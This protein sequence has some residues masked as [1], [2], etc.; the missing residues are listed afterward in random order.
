MF[1][2]LYQLILVSTLTL[3][4]GCASLPEN[5]QQIPSYAL[6]NT[7]E[8]TIAKGVAL[9]KKRDSAPEEA[10]GM[11]LIQDGLDA[12]VARAGLASTAEKTLDVQY[13]LFH[14]DLSGRLLTVALFEAAERGVRVR[15]LL[16]DMDM[17]G[18]DKDLATLNSHKNIQIRLFNPFI[19]GKSRTGQL[20]S[21]FGT[22][23]RRMHNKSF[24]A[25]N[26]IAILGGRNI[27][28]AYFS[29]DPDVEF[30]DLDVGL[31][32]P[33]VKEVS[34]SFDLYWNSPLAY[35][36]ET[37][38]NIPAKGLDL[39]ETRHRINAYKEQ[40][41]DNDYIRR[42]ENS[43]LVQR[44]KNGTTR[45]HWGD[46]KVLADHPDKIS[47]KRDQT[48][49]H[50]TPLLGPYING[51]ENELIVVSP[52]FVPGKEGVAFFKDLTSRGVT[53]KIMT[54]SLASNDVPIVHSGYMSYRKDLLEAG[55]LLYEADKR[56]SL[57]RAKGE[58]VEKNKEKA[59][60][61]GS[62][63]SKTS[64]HAKYFIMDRQQA[65][66]GSL[67]LDPRSVVENTE[68]GTL[69]DQ[70]ELAKQLA[71]DFDR[72]INKI[73]FDVYLDDGKLRWTKHAG[74]DKTVF[75]HEPYT[76]W[77]TRFKVNMM[78]ILP[79]ESQL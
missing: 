32:G 53:V 66:I 57:A 14:S 1:S 31:A 26:Q 76:S 12:F 51:V 59:K 37:L 10:S 21:R 79:A 60:L 11:L 16:D 15:L 42:L 18:A 3:L 20:V 27:G 23:T 64:L 72:D 43:N 65:F 71:E 68:I 40:H 9:R 78:R 30:G 47:E 39:D 2:R 74:D 28:D 19:R 67:N 70:P 73:A 58:K 61:F 77:W 49:Y 62:A 13:Y 48:Q 34:A 33:V 8:T 41:K 75:N 25:D 56:A 54:N 22:V 6:T 35:P 38:V 7:N 36:V 44:A 29:A 4:V 24:N 63:G 69:I 52:Y 5:N 55:V 46:A 45:W 50:L 17:A